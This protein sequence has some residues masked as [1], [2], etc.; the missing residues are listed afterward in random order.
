MLACFSNMRHSLSG[1]VPFS[2][3]FQ[4]ISSYG[5]KKN[6]FSFFYF[7]I[8][9]VGTIRWRIGETIHGEFMGLFVV[10]NW[11]GVMVIVKL[12]VFERQRWRGRKAIFFWREVARLFSWKKR[13]G[14]IDFPFFMMSVE[15]YQNR[16]TIFCSQF[17]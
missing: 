17:R 15:Y 14:T 16:G 10:G 2:K 11:W 8:K 3:I 5:C 1:S 13:V 4:N 9:L 6:S 7:P 12:C